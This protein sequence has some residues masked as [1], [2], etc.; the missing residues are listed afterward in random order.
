M[1]WSVSDSEGG[2]K[3]A[4]NPLV[5][6][7]D[8]LLSSVGAKVVMS[9]SGALLWGFIIVH[10]LGN[11]Q[12]FQG[13]DVLNEYGVKLRSL[14]PLFW[15]ARIGIYVLFAVHIF[16]GLRLAALNKKARGPEGYRQKKPLRTTPMALTMASSGLIILLFFGFHIAHFTLG[17]VSPDTSNAIDAVGRHD[18][19]H[20]VVAEFKKP[21]IVVIYLI[22]Q[23]VLLAHLIHGTYSLFQSLGLHHRVW[24]PVVKVAGRAIAALIFIGNIAIPLSILFW[25]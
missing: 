11:L 21:A 19:F 20:M 13:A 23:T 6:L 22:G 1:R 7:R 2:T 5:V 16:Y 10:L 14:G 8:F 25:N 24:S 4:P 17:V 15:I 18:V 12:V 9:I 3:A